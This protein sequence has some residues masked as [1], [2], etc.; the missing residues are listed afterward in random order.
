VL[1]SDGKV[2][3]GPDGKR[4][5]VPSVSIPDAKDRERFQAQALAALDRLLTE[6]GS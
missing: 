1:D 2:R 3:I 5:N 4:L 6:G